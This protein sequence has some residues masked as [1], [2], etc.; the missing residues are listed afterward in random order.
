ETTPNPPVPPKASPRPWRA[1]RTGEADTDER[2]YGQV[3]QRSRNRVRL[4]S[5]GSA[6]RVGS[7]RI[8]DV[9]ERTGADAAW[10]RAAWQVAGGYFWYYGAV[11]VFVPFFALYLREL[12]FGGLQIG[13]LTA[14]PSV[15]VAL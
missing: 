8:E 7:W 2:A 9:V 10:R 15:G 6:V 12:N 1:S 11:G 13:I 14:L 3:S 5:A 4:L